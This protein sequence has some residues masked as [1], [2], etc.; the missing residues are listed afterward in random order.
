MEYR[1]HITIP[2]FPETP[3]NATGFDLLEWLGEHTDMG[4]VLSGP[5]PEGAAATVA[6][7]TDAEDEASAVARMTAA[8]AAALAA[9]GLGHLYPAHV[10]LE[11][12]DDPIPA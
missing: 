8:T 5:G 12:V 9:I 3:E 6:L 7:S 4:P 2:D 10:Q 11:R 1:A